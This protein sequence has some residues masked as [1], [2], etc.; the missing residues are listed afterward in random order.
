MTS[1]RFAPHERPLL[2]DT[3]PE[4]RRALVR[5]YQQ[6]TPE[7]KATVVGDLRRMTRQ[8]F[9]AGYRARHPA[10]G[11]DELVLAWMRH[12]LD[13]ELYE[14]AR[15]VRDEYQRRRLE[16]SSQS[17]AIVRA[18]APAL[19]AGGIAGQLGAGCAAGDE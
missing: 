4:A 17:G 13:P 18:D 16:R 3:T 6:M 11:D 15:S 1:R 14:K 2:D 19:C 9:E 7:R 12:T 5:V 8:L 10:A